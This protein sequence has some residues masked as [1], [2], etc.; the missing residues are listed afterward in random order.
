[1]SPAVE[2]FLQQVANG[3]VIGSTYTV[4][5]LY[6]KKGQSLGID[7]VR[8]GAHERNQRTVQA[9]YAHLVGA[10]I[11]GPSDGRGG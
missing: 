4:V 5:A 2:L 6:R 7:S 8:S 11:A 3:V 1:M 10:A 9:R